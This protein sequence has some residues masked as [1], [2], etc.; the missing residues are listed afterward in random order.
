MISGRKN[1]VYHAEFG[2]TKTTSL[3]S[4]LVTSYELT[5]LTLLAEAIIETTQKL[6][7]PGD[8]Y[9]SLTPATMAHDA[10]FILGAPDFVELCWPEVAAAFKHKT[11]LRLGVSQELGDLTNW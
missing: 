10:L 4:Y 8:P 3:V 7:K 11:L 9:K 1:K 2:V 5:C 6:G